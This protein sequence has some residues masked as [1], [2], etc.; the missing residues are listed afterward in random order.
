MESTYG[1]MGKIRAAVYTDDQARA[2][3]QRVV[4]MLD[5]YPLSTVRRDHRA[6]C[7]AF[8]RAVY[9]VTGKLYGPDIY[10]RLLKAYAPGRSPSTSTL[11][12]E[13]DNLDYELKKAQQATA[14]PG[15]AG[16]SAGQADSVPAA[17]RVRAALAEFLPQL[18]RLVSQPGRE[19]EFDVMVARLG[20]AEQLARAEIL[21][22]ELQVCQAALAREQESVS[23]LT[24]EVAGQRT[25]ALQAIESSRAETRLVKELVIH[26]EQQARAHEDTIDMLRMARNMGQGASPR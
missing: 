24:G 14:A 1:S 22:S 4:P 12:N 26:L 10:R 2:L 7:G 19:A 13:R 20:D 6:F 25:F 5:Q 11:A 3:I 15:V 17:D 18:A 21:S 8:M 16:A 9:D 23:R